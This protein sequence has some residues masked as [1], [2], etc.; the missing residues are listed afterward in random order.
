MRYSEIKH[1]AE[2]LG[3]KR[4]VA[5]QMVGGETNLETLIKKHGLR[6]KKCGRGSADLIDAAELR[7]AWRKFF[8]EGEAC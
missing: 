8:D 6:V 5:A 3:V 1:A 4:K 2:P 7:A